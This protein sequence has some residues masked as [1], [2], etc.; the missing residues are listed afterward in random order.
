MTI[1]HWT[2]QDRIRKAREHA[3][4][5]Q[6][7]LAEL[8]PVAR[9]TLSRWESGAFKPSAADLDRLAEITDVDRT[10]LETGAEPTEQEPL[11]SSLSVRWTPN[12]I[13]VN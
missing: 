2:L 3:G 4:L 13:K 8:I 6:T 1:P 10:W 11:P 5:N 12:G 9:N 7:A